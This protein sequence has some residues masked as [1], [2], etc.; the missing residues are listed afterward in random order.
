MHLFVERIFGALLVMLLLLLQRS[1]FAVLS[2]QVWN[3]HE[4]KTLIEAGKRDCFYQHIEANTVFHVSYRIIKGDEITVD[5][6]DPTGNLIYNLVS[7]PT[8]T[9]QTQ[10]TVLTGD[11]AICLDN[12]YSHMTSKLVYLYILTFKQ[13]D[14][15]KKFQHDRD[16]NETS[17]VATEITSKIIYNLIEVHSQQA[18]ARFRQTRDEYLIESNNSLVLYWSLFQSLLIIF[19]AVFQVYFIRRLFTVKSSSSS[20]SSN[21]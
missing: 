19:C 6:A 15:M 17:H 21:R 1:A 4:F 16:L 13:E 9:Y 8:G 20:K 10:Q 3:K 14:V 5:I 2:S 11:Y 7:H 18:M 12:Q